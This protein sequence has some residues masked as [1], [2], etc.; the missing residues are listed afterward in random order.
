[1]T[2]P[3]NVLVVDIGKTN[4]KLAVVDTAAM[5]EVVVMTRPNRVLAGPPYPH[6][7]VAG[8][9]EF[10]LDGIRT[11]HASHGVGALVV[12][13]HGATAALLDAGGGLALPVLDYEHDGPD[14]LAAAYDAVRPGFEET[15]SPRLPAGLNLGAQLHWQFGRFAEASRTAAIVT[16]PQYWAYRLSG[17]ASVEPTSLGCHTDLWDPR[18]RD[19]STLVDGM[20]WRALMPPVRG[21]G[22]V[23]GPVKGDVAA[24][25]GLGEGT[26]VHC[27]IHDSNASL[28]PHL[29]ARRA[30]FAVVSTGTWVISMAIG[31]AAVPLDPARDTLI[32]VSASGDPVPSARFMGGREWSVLMEGRA[33]AAEAADRAAVLER[34]ICLLPAVEPGS[35]PFAGRPRRW[36]V[37]EEELSDGQRAVV[38]S[39]YL[40][41]VTSVCLG[42]IGARGPV[43]VEGP[44]AANGDYR[45]MLAAA[46]GRPVVAAAGATGTSVGAALLAAPV[47]QPLDGAAE[48]PDRGEPVAGLSGYADRWRALVGVS[49]GGAGRAG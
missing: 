48:P 16:Y 10:I 45:D 18:R 19:F 5:S 14:G 46:T 4:A 26:P 40:A 38:V 17:V 28:L 31:G 3:G 1:V 12:T 37:A 49:P 2:V 36:S 44:F 34:G 47:R 11:L 30:P 9:W 33:A 23:L 24:A 6:A 42:E 25:T 13:T 8:L 27:G 29:R 21:A 7:D 39:Y 32:N 20:G 43:V 35:G 15:G 41:L 22:E